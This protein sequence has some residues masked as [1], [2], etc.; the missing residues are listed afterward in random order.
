MIETMTLPITAYAVMSDP[1]EI[2]TAKLPRYWME[3]AP[4]K[5]PYRCL[6]MNIANQAGWEFLNPVAFEASWNGGPAPGDVK[7]RFLDKTISNL[8][9]AHFGE[10][11]L[12]FSVGYLFRTPENWNMWVR[13]PANS[14]KDGIQWLEGIVETDWSFSTFTMNWLFTRPTKVVFEAGEPFCV[15]CPYPRGA[16]ESV[17]PEIKS[18]E[19]NPELHK[20]YLE[21][22]ALRNKFNHDLRVSGSQA[23][24][25]GW[26]KDY[27]KGVGAPGHH[28]TKL[29]LADFADLRDAD[30]KHYQSPKST[31]RPLKISTPGKPDMTLM[32]STNFQVKNEAANS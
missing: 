19:S 16:L 9:L 30:K 1:P 5:F 28:H 4:H 25:E 23:V 29:A 32:V 31:V 10:G 8:P 12:T 21:W 11:V 24:Q 3:K 13:G 14:P 17:V 6:P 20:K 18:P 26:Q 2:R 22:S 15:V 7:I 27:F